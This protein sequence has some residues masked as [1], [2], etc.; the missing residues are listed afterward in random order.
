MLLTGCI[1]GT[2]LSCVSGVELAKGGLIGCSCGGLDVV[3]GDVGLVGLRRFA[4]EPPG[5]VQPS[6]S[7]K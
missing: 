1:E 6:T 4:A 7:K 2:V 3:S 5:C